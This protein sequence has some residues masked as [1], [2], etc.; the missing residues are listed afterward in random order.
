MFMSACLVDFGLGASC[1]AKSPL[2][3]SL[4]KLTLLIL[5]GSLE[6]PLLLVKP[7]QTKN[8]RD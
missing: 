7:P 1:P 5:I 6:A 8:F 4:D 3:F 2:C